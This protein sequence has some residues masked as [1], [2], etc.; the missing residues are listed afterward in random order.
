MYEE[1]ASSVSLV[2]IAAIDLGPQC[3]SINPRRWPEA[4][5]HRFER[6]AQTSILPDGGNFV[7]AP[8]RLKEK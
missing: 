6:I 5:K 8:E 7:V 4:H 1:H 3:W 2:S